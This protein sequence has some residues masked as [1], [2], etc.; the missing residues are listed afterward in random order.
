MLADAPD[1]RLLSA[2][3]GSFPQQGWPPLRRPQACKD[4]GMNRHGHRRLAPQQDRTCSRGPCL[5]LRPHRQGPESNRSEQDSGLMDL[6]GL[7]RPPARSA[8]FTVGGWKGAA[9]ALPRPS[10]SVGL[11]GTLQPPHPGQALAGLREGSVL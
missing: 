5:V 7:S 8:V 11:H 1:L 2:N 9:P 10:G 3:A 6:A 4:P